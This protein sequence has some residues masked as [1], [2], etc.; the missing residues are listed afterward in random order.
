MTVP[1]TRRTPG[2]SPR[3]RPAT[4]LLV[5]SFGRVA[6]DLRVSLTEKCSLRCTYCMPAEG[7]PWLAKPEMLT[8]DELVGICS[9]LLVAGHETTSNMLGLGTLALLQ[10]PDQLALVRDDPDAVSPAA[11]PATASCSEPA[12]CAC[13]A[14]LCCSSVTSAT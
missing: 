12:S 9:L 1:D 10:H 3:T 5:D 7:L 2:A 8:D 6:R 11:A 4:P 14:A 13:R